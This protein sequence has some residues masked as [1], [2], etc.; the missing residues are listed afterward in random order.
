VN[1]CNQLFINDLFVNRWRNIQ[2]GGQNGSQF[3]QTEQMVQ[4][5]LP[6][7]QDMHRAWA[8]KPASPSTFAV[9]LR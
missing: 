4:K 9:A 3:A 8:I 6:N 1:I 5:Y 7:W 2:W